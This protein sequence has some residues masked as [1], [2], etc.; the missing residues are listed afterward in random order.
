MLDNVSFFLTDFL[1]LFS[2]NSLLRF[3][4]NEVFRQ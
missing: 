4:I 1:K 3:E 2:D